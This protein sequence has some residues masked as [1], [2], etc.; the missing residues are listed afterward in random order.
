MKL[1]FREIRKDSRSF[2][3]VVEALVFV[4]VNVPKWLS[5]LA[6]PASARTLGVASPII[7]IIVAYNGVDHTYA[8]ASHCDTK[9]TWLF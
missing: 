2:E 7:S 1:V 3:D 4:N 8:S 5:S 6:A 9:S